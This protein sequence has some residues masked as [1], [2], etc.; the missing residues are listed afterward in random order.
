MKASVAGFFYS[1][2]FTVVHRHYCKITEMLLCHDGP[3]GY[4]LILFIK[5]KEHSASAL[6]IGSVHP[7]RRSQW[8]LGMILCHRHLV[9]GELLVIFIH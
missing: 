2:L 9:L 6:E 4:I 8:I 3:C 5:L 1:S 7:I